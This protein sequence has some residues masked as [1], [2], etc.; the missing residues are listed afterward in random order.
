M[1]SEP[2]SAGSTA[3]VE[4]TPCSSISTSSPGASSRSS[5]AP[6]RSSAQVSE[7]RIHSPCSPRP[8][9]SGRK[10]CRSR[11]PTSVP[12]ESATPQ[13]PPPEPRH[14]AGD[15]VLERRLVVGDQSGDQLRVGG[16][17][18]RDPLGL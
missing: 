2:C 9:Q 1:Q 8:R 16:G 11:K 12:F 4:R 14:R 5:S 17:G 18:E 6:T 15:R 10:P 13:K 7:A 3:W